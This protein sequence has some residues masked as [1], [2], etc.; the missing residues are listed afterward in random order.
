VNAFR[1]INTLGVRLKME[2]IESAEIA[3]RHSGF[4][5]DEVV[6]FLDSL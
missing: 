5:T 2:D 4:I 3:A 1:R 6:P